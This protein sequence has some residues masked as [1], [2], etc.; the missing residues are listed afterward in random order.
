VILNFSI[1]AWRS[2]DRM[3]N[4]KINRFERKYP[5][6]NSDQMGAIQRK[7]KLRTSSS[8]RLEAGSAL[9][10]RSARRPS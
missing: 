3:G 10:T 6:I 1:I 2:G 5:V 4:I 7:T 9:S 8:I